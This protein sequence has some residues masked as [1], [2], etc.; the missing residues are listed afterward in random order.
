MI[1]TRLAA[2]LAS[3]L[4]VTG[5][6]VSFFRYSLVLAGTSGGDRRAAVAKRDPH[7]RIAL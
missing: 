5:S 3:I 2:R 6:R 4:H 7:I 1:E